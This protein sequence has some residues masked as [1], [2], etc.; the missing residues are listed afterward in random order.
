MHNEEH[1]EVK[2]SCIP[3]SG[4]GLFTKRAIKKGE[5]IVEYKGEIVS[6]KECIKRAENDQ[7]GYM[8][9]IN[10]KRCIDAY[11]TPEAIA[12]YANDAK[13]I[14]RIKGKTNNAVYAIHNNKAWIQATKNIKAGEE[15]FVS[16]GSGYWRDIK[17][18]IKIDQQQDSCKN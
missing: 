9:F 7:Y 1:L 8:F 10:N 12:R 13:G 11:L 15:I 14:S 17:H 2:A 4:K 6:W 3:N 5:F 16:Y 18:N